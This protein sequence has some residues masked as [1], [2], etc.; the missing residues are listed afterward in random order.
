MPALLLVALTLPPSAAP[1]TVSAKHV[2]HLITLLADEDVA[3]RK[4]AMRQLEALDEAA[5]P[6]LDDATKHPDVD[7]RLR[8]FT[9]RRA[10]LSQGRGLVRAFGSGAALTAPPPFGGYWLNR[11][12]FSRDGKYAVAAGGGLILYDLATGKETGRTLEFGGARQ[13]LAVSA[14]GKH[15][16]TA[17]SASAIVHLVELPSLKLV[18]SFKGHAIGASGVALSPD[19]TLAATCGSDR[20]IRVWD[21]KSGKELRRCTE[22]TGYPHSVAF[23]ADGKRLLAGL[24]GQPA[25]Q[26]A[27]LF[28]V[29]T[30]KLVRTYRGHA[31]NLTRVLF[32]AEGK[33]ILA[34]GMDGK[35]IVWDTETAKALHT[36]T[37]G[38][39]VYDLALSP[40][41]KR[42]LTA[43][44][45]DR[46]I[47]LWDVSSGKL[48]ESF[49][50][51]Q[52]SVLGVAF[53]ADGRQALSCDAVCCVR[54]WKVGR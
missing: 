2:A 40:N 39:T 37:H 20:T 13:G 11:V 10:I 35:L 48:V 7:V 1:P 45:A 38:G 21:V 53:S 12:Q 52:G 22:F 5:L 8:A 18:Q 16:L 54:L 15:A 44:F 29:E 17:H 42:A 36:M 14:D 6:A 23:S 3:V 47:K 26:M 19:A 33:T 49:E 51:H 43:G 46:L 24:S 30:G 32:G 25:D 27:R 4:N 28:D 9:I 41:G 31:G 34:S 50:G